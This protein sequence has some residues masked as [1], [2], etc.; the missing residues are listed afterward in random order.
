MPSPVTTIF[1]IAPLEERREHKIVRITHPFLGVSTCAKAKWKHPGK[2]NQKVTLKGPH[3]CSKGDQNFNVDPQR[4][5][6]T[7]TFMLPQSTVTAANMQ[8]EV[9]MIMTTIPE[10]PTV[11]TS[12]TTATTTT[13]VMPIFT[14]V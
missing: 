12:T 7:L 4:P 9:T 10:I 1:P 8:T 14:T 3:R 5:S 6:M 13:V 11:S 2:H